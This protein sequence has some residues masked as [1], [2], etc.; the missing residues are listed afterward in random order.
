MANN[1][2]IDNLLICGAHLVAFF[3][4]LKLSIT[5]AILFPCLALLIYKHRKDIPAI[6]KELPIGLIAPL[7]V[8]I[9]CALVTGLFGIAPINSLTQGARLIV[10]ILTLSL[11]YFVTIKT[12]S[13]RLLI[14][15]LLGQSISSL[16]TVIT[17]I[18]PEFLTRIFIGAVTESGQLAI[19]SLVAIGITFTILFEREKLETPNWVAFLTAVNL[20]GFSCVG[21]SSPSFLQQDLWIF[22]VILSISTTISLLFSYKE[23]KSTKSCFTLLFSLTLPLLFSALMINLK[24]GPWLGVGVA[25]ILLIGNYYKRLVLPVIALIIL[26]IFSVPQIQTRLRESS[27]DFFIAGGRSEMWQIGTELAAKYPLGIGY[28][29]SAVLKK[30]DANIPQNHTHFH[31]NPLNILVETGWLGLFLFGAWIL[32]IIR[33]GKTPGVSFPNSFLLYALSLS[34]ISW[35]VAGIV[36]YNFGDS[37][38]LLVVLLVISAMGNLLNTKTRQN[39]N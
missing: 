28:Q 32:K 5:Y 39:Q 11:F 22:L 27:D 3:I 31:N 17:P 4:P 15:L 20:I 33:A 16:H 26:V 34:I 12:S 10:P 18:L 23:W 13:K 35:Q 19:S 1:S 29:N 8:W 6:F 14:A 2:R 37:E 24:R 7:I 25:L 21:F 30:F 38:V 9:V 36:E